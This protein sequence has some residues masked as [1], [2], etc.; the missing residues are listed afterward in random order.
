MSFQ[1][2]IVFDNKCVEEGFLPG[3]GFSALIYNFL[4]QDYLLFD[5]GGNSKTL[6]HN[7]NKLNVDISRIKKVII[8]HNHSDHVG[9]LEGIYKLNSN[10]EV[11]IPLANLMSYKKAFFDLKVHGISELTRIGEN[12]YSSGQFGQHSIQEQSLFLRTK[13]NEIIIVVGC[14]HPGLERFILEAQNLGKIIAIIGGFHGFNKFSYLN[15]VNLIGACHCTKHIKSI[16]ELYPNQ[17]KRI[18]VGNSFSF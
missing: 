10:I 16:R 12:L 15:G 2:S 3:F 4:S 6:I 18:C 11:Y 14:A 8:S 9:G 5:T 1:L 17:Y 13:K 7:I